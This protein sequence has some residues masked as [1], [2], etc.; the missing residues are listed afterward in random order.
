ML[1]DVVRVLSFCALL[2][3]DDVIVMFFDSLSLKKEGNGGQQW[4]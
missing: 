2:H 4:H 1:Q 3:D